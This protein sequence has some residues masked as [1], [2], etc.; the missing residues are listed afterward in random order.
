MG[1]AGLVD[2][3]LWAIARAPRNLLLFAIVSLGTF[4]YQELVPGEPNYGEAGIPWGWV[5]ITL[6][7]VILLYRRVR[8]AWFLSL[9]LNLLTTIVL[10][11]FSTWPWTPKYAG[12]VVLSAAAT[13]LLASSAVRRYMDEKP[14]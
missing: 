7:L 11:L 1:S 3:V 14:F 6:V 8:L 5:L 9:M 2:R 12:L 13:V 4:A 10:V